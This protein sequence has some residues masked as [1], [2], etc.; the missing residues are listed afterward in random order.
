MAL[1]GVDMF[2]PFGKFVGLRGVDDG[3]AG[4]EEEEREFESAS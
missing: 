1:E 2:R 3:V 4:D